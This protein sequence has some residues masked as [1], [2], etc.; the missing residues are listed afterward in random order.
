MH[1][2]AELIQC[3]LSH[4]EAFTPLRS[5]WERDQDFFARLDTD[6]DLLN[7]YQAMLRKDLREGSK[8]AEVKIIVDALI[9]RGVFVVKQ[10]EVFRSVSHRLQEDEKFLVGNRTLKEVIIALYLMKDFIDHKEMHPSLSAV[11]R[12]VIQ[13]NTQNDPLPAVSESECDSEC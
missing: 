9:N 3:S 10:R 11:S 6:S 12:S 13:G 1:R 8:E 7:V 5:M 4:E 2:A